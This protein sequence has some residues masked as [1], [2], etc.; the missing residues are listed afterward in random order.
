MLSVRQSIGINTVLASP[1]R[2]LLCDSQ[3][4]LGL[5]WSVNPESVYSS[6]IFSFP[7]KTDDI[8][9]MVMRN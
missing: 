1:A 2:T 7:L 8:D 4:I 5:D 9:V 3:T 6:S